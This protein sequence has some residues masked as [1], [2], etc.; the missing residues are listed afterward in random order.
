MRRRALMGAVLVLATLVAF[1]PAGYRP[2][3][4]PPSGGH[5]TPSGPQ[6][7]PPAYPGSQVTWVVRVPV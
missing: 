7:S 1:V 2:K 3:P 6:T 4:E 5:T